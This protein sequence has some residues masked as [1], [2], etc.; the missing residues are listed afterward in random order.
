[1][2]VSPGILP[3]TIIH[4][5]PDGANLLGMCL[6]K[7]HVRGKKKKIGG[8]KM[9][10]KRGRTEDGFERW[11]RP[12]GVPSCSAFLNTSPGSY[13]K[14]KRAVK[15]HRAVN[16]G[17]PECFHCALKICKCRGADSE[18]LRRGSR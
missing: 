18:S 17:A 15:R 7:H 16:Q 12:C 14:Q 5:G 13:S 1:M 6:H 4:R 8:M 10:V 3:C 2:S 9:W 11:P